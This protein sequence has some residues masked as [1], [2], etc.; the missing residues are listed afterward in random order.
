M[1]SAWREPL[2]A[3]PAEPSA[4]TE[5][6][7][8]GEAVGCPPFVGGATKACLDCCSMSLLS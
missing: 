8:A 6:K 5:R 4:G 3:K 1:V 7:R 2:S